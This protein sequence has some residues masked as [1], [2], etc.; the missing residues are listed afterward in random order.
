MGAENIEDL[1]K[2][3]DELEKR[4]KASEAAATK[5]E[6]ERAAALAGNSTSHLRVGPMSDS[7]EAKALKLYGAKSADDLLQTNVGDPKF[8][9][10]P[11]E[12]KGYVLSFKEAF[13]NARNLQQMF[14]GQPSDRNEE[15]P[16]KVKGILDGT[17]YGRNVV[18]PMVKAF[19]S[20]IGGAGDEWVPTG[21]AS[22]FVEEYELQR[23]V[24]QALRQINLPTAPF[25]L[26]VQNNVTE[27]RIQAENTA[28]TDTNF[29]TTAIQFSPTKLNEFYIMPE[30]LNEDSAPA[31]LQL[32]RAEVVEAQSR[33]YEQAV[34]NGDNDGTH[35]DS[36][37]DA[38]SATL[39]AKAWDG[40]RNLA[41]ANSAT[42][43]FGAAAS[44]ALLRSMRAAMGKHGVNPK[45]LMWIASPKVYNQ[46]LGLTEVTTFEK[47]GSQATILTGSLAALDGIRIYVSE[48]MRDDLNA[49]GVYD[50]VTTTKTGVLLVNHRRMWFGTRRPI[51]TKV[52]MDLPSQDRW[53]M[54]S[55]SRVDFQAHAQSASEVSINY[56]IN[57]S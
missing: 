4:I 28:A 26:P 55:W 25:D 27:A 46:M 34:I 23:E 21:M 24:V 48:Y 47:Y 54:A 17:N 19:G 49:S 44:T 29:G 3:A 52:I 7:V 9:W 6:E 57:V 15:K 1:Q 33:A 8:A 53:L 31:I 36:D 30:E 38:G 45:E 11:E 40:L 51:R 16:S 56:G 10:V 37:T 20:T 5:A 22:S 14:G 39:A 18:A 50:G 42:I 35:Q 32:A 43:D 12:V 2:Q 41:V 13:M